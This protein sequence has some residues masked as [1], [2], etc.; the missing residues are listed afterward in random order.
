PAQVRLLVV[1]RARVVDDEQNV[2]RYR[3][4]GRYNL[5]HLLDPLRRLLLEEIA[6][7]AGEE[8]SDRDQRNRCGSARTGGYHGSHST[9]TSSRAIRTSELLKSSWQIES[10]MQTF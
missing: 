6:R 9:M 2:R 5:L 10:T 3:L 1:H 7:T 8:R 4:P